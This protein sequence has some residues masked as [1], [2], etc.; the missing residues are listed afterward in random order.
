MR[1]KKNFEGI[2]VEIFKVAFSILG[3]LIRKDLAEW[4]KRLSANANV[5]KV[6]GSIPVSSDTVE[7]DGGR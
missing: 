2:L 5:K 1:F 6:L 3:G 7:S 4:F